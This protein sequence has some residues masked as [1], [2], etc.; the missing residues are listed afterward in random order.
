MPLLLGG[1]EVGRT[2]GG[3]NN[4]YCQDNAISWVDWPAADAELIEFVARLSRL[5][6]ELPVLR[7][8]RFFGPGDIQWL[9]P[10]GAP[11]DAGDWGNPEARAVTVAVADGALLVNAWWEP[12]TFRLPRDGAWSVALDTADP[13]SR[14]VVADTVE[15]A[16]RSLALVN[17][18]S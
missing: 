2:Q 5:R 16:D 12:L 14:R 9:R 8:T 18:L 6:R 1:D 17:A 13:C 11:M 3:N 15:L 4:A 7:R 10:D